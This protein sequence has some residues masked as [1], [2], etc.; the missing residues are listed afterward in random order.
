LLW[1]IDMA[2][3]FTKEFGFQYEEDGVVI[4][5]GA[6]EISESTFR[7]LFQQQGMGLVI[8]QDE[9]GGPIAV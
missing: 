8:V 6:R 3:Y 2:I 9:K 1:G 4:P 5:E 7:Q